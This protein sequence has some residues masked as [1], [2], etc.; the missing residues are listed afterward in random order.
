M[1]LVYFVLLDTKD[2]NATI[3]GG[4]D[5]RLDIIWIVGPEFVLNAMIGAQ[6]IL[7]QQNKHTGRY[8]ENSGIRKHIESIDR[9]DNIRFG[10]LRNYEKI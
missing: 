1:S 3:Y 6:T 8:E 4:A 10:S 9:H 7:Q 2:C 5:I